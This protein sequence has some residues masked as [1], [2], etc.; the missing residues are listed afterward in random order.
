MERED[1]YVEVLERARCSQGEREA[2]LGVLGRAAGDSMGRAAFLMM[3]LKLLEGSDLEVYGWARE[4]LEG[5]LKVTAFSKLRWRTTVAMAAVMG[6]YWLPR[7]GL[8]AGAQGLVEGVLRENE[9]SLFYQVFLRSVDYRWEELLRVASQMTH[10][11]GDKRYEIEIT[12]EGERSAGV[13][14]LGQD[15]E[16]VGYLLPGFVRGIAPPLGV[17]VEVEVLEEQ[18]HFMELLLRW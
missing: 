1:F 3:C 2:L 15:A 8:R 18:V 6:S 10:F 4:V 12:R 16:A 13:K 17:E 5:E 11:G 9:G 14:L 7:K